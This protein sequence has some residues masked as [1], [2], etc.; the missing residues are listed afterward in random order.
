MKINVNAEIESKTLTNSIKFHG[1][2]NA[3][4][5]ACEDIK[6]LDKFL[7]NIFWDLI[8][9]KRQAESNPYMKSSQEIR[10]EL[11]KLFKGLETMSNFYFERDEEEQQMKIKCEVQKSL[12]QL[13]EWARKNDVRNKIFQSQGGYSAYFDYEGCLTL[14]KEFQPQDFFAVKEEIEITEDT[15]LDY[16]LLTFESDNGKIDTAYYENDYISSVLNQ[17]DRLVYVIKQLSITYFDDK[18]IPH[19]IWETD[20]GLVEQMIGGD[21]HCHPSNYSSDLDYINNCIRYYK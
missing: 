5:K 4:D 17:S 8:R 21:N 6:E 14:T 10:A 12:P 20:K 13:I 2:T 15:R 18:G 7:E 9:T 11:D 1:E 19:L 16:L 3:D